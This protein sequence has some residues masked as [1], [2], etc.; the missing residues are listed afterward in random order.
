LNKDKETKK[1]NTGDNIDVSSV[2]KG[3]MEE[4]RDREKKKL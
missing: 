2:I 3:M 4:T 1:K